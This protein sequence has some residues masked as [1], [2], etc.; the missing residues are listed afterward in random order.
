MPKLILL[1]DDEDG[2][3]Q[4]IQFSLEAA[5]GWKV[6]T[7]ASG[8]E[9]LE[10]AAGEKP[11]AILLDVMM[12][13]MDGIA[14]FQ[15]L[16][17]N[18][19]TQPIPVILLTAKTPSTEQNYLATLKVAGIIIKPFKIQALVAFIRSMLQWTD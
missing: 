11:D 9:G 6:L 10:I 7:A 8:P 5:A 14:T 1:I 17:D 18:P 15:C 19:I 16:Q 4:I 13:D 2:A 3:R 12:P